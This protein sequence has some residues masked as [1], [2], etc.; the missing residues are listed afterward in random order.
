MH[1]KKVTKVLI[2]FILLLVSFYMWV[3]GLYPIS[4]YVPVSLQTENKDICDKIQNNE[5][6]E[7]CIQELENKSINI[8]KYSY[9]LNKYNII[10]GRCGNEFGSPGYCLSRENLEKI[11]LENKKNPLVCKNLSGDFNSDV[12]RTPISYC[13]ALTDNPYFCGRIPLDIMEFSNA[14]L[15]RRECYIDMA[16]IWKDP[17]LCEKLK[18]Q[19]KDLCYL[20]FSTAEKSIK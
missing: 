9:L 2:I 3:N 20:I 14:D 11:L 17:S 8:E 18:N 5:F 13:R 19:E 4:S 16:R 12:G 1:N 15:Q 7:L 10:T 6:R